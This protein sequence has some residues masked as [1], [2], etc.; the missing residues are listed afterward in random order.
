[1]IPHKFYLIPNNVDKKILKGF[2]PSEDERD[3]YNS[4]QYVIES[5]IIDDDF[6]DYI[7]EHLGE[8]ELDDVPCINPSKSSL[9]KMDGYSRCGDSLF[10][11]ESAEKLIKTFLSWKE[12]IKDKTDEFTYA[13]NGFD[14]EP[15][16]KKEIMDNLEK[17]IDCSKKLL[18]K[19]YY[20]YHIGI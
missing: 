6:I 3:G 4:K 13:E 1:M 9:P 15:F 17:A 16:N 20:I 7:H 5:F 18:S 10:D 8:N 11:E 2:F 12:L 19:K 14:D